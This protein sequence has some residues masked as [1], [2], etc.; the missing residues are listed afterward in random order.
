MFVVEMFNKGF[1]AD[2]DFFIADDVAKLFVS[3]TDADNFIAT[4]SQSEKFLTEI[5]NTCGCLE[6][7]D[8]VALM[9]GITD[10]SIY[11]YCVD[12]A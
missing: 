11:A 12:C 10:D 2:G 7:G 6:D 4:A 3:K 9:M 8:D 1:N 5:A